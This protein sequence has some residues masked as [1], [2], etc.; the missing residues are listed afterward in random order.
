MK[1]FSDECWDEWKGS[2]WDYIWKLFLTKLG[3]LWESLPE[4]EYK[5]HFRVED[6]KEKWGR[7][8]TFVTYTGS[9]E[10]RDLVSALEHTSSYTCLQCGKQTKD[11]FGNY[12]VWKSKGWIAPYCKKCAKKFYKDNNYV[13]GKN[14]KATY[15]RVKCKPYSIH[16]IM[17]PEGDYTKK[18]KRLEDF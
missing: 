3:K 6:T 1:R 15:T 4:G 11:L 5:D 7:L 12:I 17:S 13:Y 18:I 2:G 16:K 8:N 10:I 14:W 9:E